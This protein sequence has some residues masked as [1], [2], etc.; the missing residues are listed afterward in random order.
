VVY[1]NKSL[2]NDAK[3]VHQF[4]L[5]EGPQPKSTVSSAYAI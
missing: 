2:K 3:P 5:V 1:L 4:I